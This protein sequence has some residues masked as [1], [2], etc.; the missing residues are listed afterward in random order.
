[1][2]SESSTARITGRAFS[3]M[4]ASVS[5]PDPELR[6]LQELGVRLG[7]HRLAVEKALDFVAAVAAQEAQLGVG[8]DALG[9]HLE[10]QGMAERDDRLREGPVV[11][12]G[13]AA[14]VAHERA[15]DLERVDRQIL[16]VG[17]ARI[18]GAEVVERKRDTELLQAL[19]DG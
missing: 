12:L 11:G 19:Q 5:F 4:G 18:A 16:E 15:V 6:L 14:D 8:L 3:L 13:A 7:R 17:K 9:D 2:S 1:M 10:V